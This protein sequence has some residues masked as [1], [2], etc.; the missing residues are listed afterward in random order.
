[1]NVLLMVYMGACMCLHVTMSM[2]LHVMYVIACMCSAL[3][4]IVCILLY[5][6]L[7][8]VVNG[9]TEQL[10]A[11]QTEF[12]S[13][14]KLVYSSIWDQSRE[15]C[16]AM[17]QIQKAAIPRLNRLSIGRSSQ[18][19]LFITL[20]NGMLLP[21]YEKIPKLAEILQHMQYLSS[22]LGNGS[23]ASTELAD[24]TRVFVVVLWGCMG[25]VT[26]FL[27]R[28]QLEANTLEDF[29]KSRLYKFAF[30]E[31][32]NTARTHLQQL[33]N[34]QMRLNKGYKPTAAVPDNLLQKMFEISGELTLENSNQEFLHTEHL[35]NTLVEEVS[36][37]A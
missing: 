18:E 37:N 23:Y 1:M 4:R 5:H 35:L 12:Q 24:H 14:L 21:V 31:M 13:D 11:W 9:S 36:Q 7:A 2:F 8:P 17:A 22:L 26:A 28:F 16:T 6:N 15:V 27:S 33:V 3:M 10:F 29:K 25:E 20:I 34:L 30:G 32:I 19:A